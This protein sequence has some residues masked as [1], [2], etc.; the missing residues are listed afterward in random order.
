MG[1]QNIQT[2]RQFLGL[3]IK[4]LG[5]IIPLF[6][7]GVLL[8]WVLS[9]VTADGGFISFTQTLLSDNFYL[10][11]IVGFTAQMIDGALG[12]AYGATSTSFL[13]STGVPPAVASSGVHVA[14]VFTTGI[15]G[16]SHWKM[17]NVDKS[18]F[19]K[20]VIPGMVGAGLGAFVLSSF[21]GKIIKPYVS[22]YLLI[23]GVIVL[24]RSFRKTII[25][26]KVKR[27]PVLAVFGG[28]VDAS[29]GG[30]WGPVVTTTLLSTGSIP[31]YTIGTVNAVEFLVALTASGVF[32][33]MIGLSLWPV[34]L[35]LILGGSFA[36]PLGAY[37]CH[38]IPVRPALVVVGLLI[39]FLSLNNLNSFFGWL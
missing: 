35:G 26:R 36:A 12:M 37:V 22:A 32:S 29:G 3:Y 34:I 31:R 14:E 1:N 4:T 20:L 17:G 33:I 21:D 30:G 19:K 7:V 39:I 5:C 16:F 18:L 10:Y 38:K 25:F 27:I 24:S 11:V 28:F 13:I 15:S 23:L 2:F 8:L 6:L 9:P